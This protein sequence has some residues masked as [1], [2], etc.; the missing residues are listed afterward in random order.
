MARERVARHRI[1]A[2]GQPVAE[3][4]V[5]EMALDPALEAGAQPR[6]FDRITDDAPAHKI[7]P[8]VQGREIGVDPPPLRLGVGIG[9]EQGDGGVPPAFERMVHRHTSRGSHMGGGARQSDVNDAQVEAWEQTALRSYDRGGLVRAIVENEHN[10]QS[11]APVAPGLTRQG[12]EK[13]RKAFGLATGG[14]C[15]DGHSASGTCFQGVARGWGR[16]VARGVTPF[17]YLHGRRPAGCAADGF[18]RV[19]CTELVGALAI[20]I[21]VGSV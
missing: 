4:C 21:H 9:R 20:E 6:L 2:G 19:I 1:D 14:D 17:G 10:G 5:S 16:K 12:S 13:A 3:L 18:A 11:I 8:R 7:G 15:H